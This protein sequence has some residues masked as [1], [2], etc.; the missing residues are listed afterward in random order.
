[1]SE[2]LRRASGADRQ[3][4]QGDAGRAEPVGSGRPDLDT[5]AGREGLC[6]ESGAVQERAGKESRAVMTVR[7]SRAAHAQAVAAAHR[8]LCSLNM[9]CVRAIL[10]RVDRTLR[11]E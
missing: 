9:F 3:T 4:L 6:Q 7:M 5:A 8:E 10:A 11:E 2:S 1:M